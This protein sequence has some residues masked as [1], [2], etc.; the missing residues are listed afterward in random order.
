M[1]LEIA[2]DRRPPW[3]LVALIVLFA[4]GCQPAVCEESYSPIV[5]VLVGAP[6]PT[7][8]TV[9]LAG[10]MMSGID[11]TRE[12]PGGVR[13]GA[14]IAVV[15]ACVSMPV[16]GSSMPFLPFWAGL[17]GLAVAMVAIVVLS[18]VDRQL[19]PNQG[20]WTHAV[21]DALQPSVASRVVA[22][23][24]VVVLMLITLV[25]ATLTAFAVYGAGLTCRDYDEAPLEEVEKQ[26]PT[27]SRSDLGSRV[28]TPE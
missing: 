18:L 17:V 8:V 6:I 1:M 14:L 13:V 10:L 19:D 2:P 24:L 28:P 15:M 5:K 23:V 11:R 3:M 16:V 25:G 4:G 9:V 26:A 12:Q 21:A 7:L 20:S 27:E 22:A